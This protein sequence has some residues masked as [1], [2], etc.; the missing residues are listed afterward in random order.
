LQDFAILHEVEMNQA[1]KIFCQCSTF[2]CITENSNNV[3]FKKLIFKK[4]KKI[5]NFNK[6]IYKNCELNIVVVPEYLP[7]KYKL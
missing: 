4:K 6:F 1:H 2:H 7:R 5:L 3:I